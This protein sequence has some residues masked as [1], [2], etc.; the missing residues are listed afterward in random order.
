[1]AKYSCEQCWFFK[2]D[3]K[4][5]GYCRRHAPVIMD[6]LNSYWPS[7]EK[8]EFCGDFESAAAVEG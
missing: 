6:N 2:E 1:M 8:S 5:S 4:D 3:G 7:V